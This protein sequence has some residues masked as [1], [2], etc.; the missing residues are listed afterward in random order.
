MAEGETPSIVVDNGSSTCKAGFAGDDAP[1]VIF[2]SIVGRP[3]HRDVLHD[4]REKDGYVGDEAVS[5]RGRCILEKRYNIDF[6]YPIENGIVTNWDDMEK[7]SS[8]SQT[9]SF[10]YRDLANH[11]FYSKFQIWHHAFFKELRIDTKEHSILLTEAPLNPKPNREKTTQV[12]NF[13]NKSFR[14]GVNITLVSCEENIVLHSH[15]ADLL[16]IFFLG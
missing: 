2:P 5:R 4:T 1:R 14:S 9:F 11:E 10:C 13:A 8:R 3:K 7:V 15:Y 16:G 12:T 6:R